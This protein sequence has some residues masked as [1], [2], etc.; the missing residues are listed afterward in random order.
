MKPNLSKVFLGGFAGTVAMTLMMYFVAPMMLGKPMDIAAMLGSV[1]GGSWTLGMI[2]HLM[3][4]AVIF[5]LLFAFVVVRFLPGPAAVKGMGWGVALWVVAQ[6]VVM[7]MMGAGFFS[8]NAGGMMAAVASLMGHLVYG[9]LL[10][11]VGAA[12]ALAPVPA[13]A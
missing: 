1:M 2:A 3:N 5:P 7:P 10:G 4:G 9:A 6:V 12:P 8:A 11:S 13:R